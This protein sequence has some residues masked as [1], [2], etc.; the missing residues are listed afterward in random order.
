MECPFPHRPGKPKS[1]TP[2][3]STGDGICIGAWTAR[4]KQGPGAL[5]RSGKALSKNRL[6]KHQDVTLVLSEG[7]TGQFLFAALFQ[8]P[9]T[10]MVSMR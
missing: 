8:F 4:A 2:N 1:P 5:W 9:G 6:S 7:E 10:F 3:C